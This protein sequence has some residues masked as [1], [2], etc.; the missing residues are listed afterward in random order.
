M[1]Q[2][3]ATAVQCLAVSSPHHVLLLEPY[4]SSCERRELRSSI[5]A[6]GHGGREAFEGLGSSSTPNAHRLV[7][8]NVAMGV[9]PGTSLIA[10]GSLQSF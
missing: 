10:T 3:A 8:C 5:T 2:R 9:L 7:G 1:Q 4:V 6:L